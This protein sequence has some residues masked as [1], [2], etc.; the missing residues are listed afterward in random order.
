MK[1]KSR[2]H[3]QGF[4]L[5][6]MQQNVTPSSEVSDMTLTNP[7]ATVTLSDTC[8]P[9][10]TLQSAPIDTPLVE[11]DPGT[12]AKQEVEPSGTM[13]E[14]TNAAPDQEHLRQL[15]GRALHETSCASDTQAL[16]TASSESVSASAE[17]DPNEIFAKLVQKGAFKISELRKD[18]IMTVYHPKSS[19]GARIEHFED[20]RARSEA[21]DAVPQDDNPDARPWHPF[22]TCLDFEFAA[23]TVEAH[24]NHS[25]IDILL[26]IIKKV[27]PNCALFTLRSV[28]D[29]EKAWNNASKLRTNFEKH[30]ISAK[31]KHQ[32]F[33]YELYA[34]PL[35]KW[36]EDELHNPALLPYIYWDSCKMYKYNDKT[37]LSS[38]GTAKGYP[39]MAGITNIAACQRNG[40]GIGSGRIVGW[41]PIVPE[42]ADKKGKT[43]FTN[44]KRRLLYPFIHILSA[45]YEEQSVMALT[46][47]NNGLKPCPV[48]NISPELQFKVR[49]IQIRRRADNV[50]TVVLDDT[51]SR[52][53]KNELL[54]PLGLRAEQNAF[55]LV[56]NSD[57]HEAL[58][59]DRL[60]ANA[61]GL[62][63]NH[64][65]PTFQDCVEKALG[66]SAMGQIDQQMASLPCWC[67]LNHFAT[68]MKVHFT[69]G[70]KYE[71]IMKV[72]STSIM[73]I[74]FAVHNVVTESADPQ[75]YL[76]LRCMRAYLEH[77]M[78]LALELHTEQ[79]I[80]SGQAWL[81]H[82]SDLIDV[83]ANITF[84]NVCANL[85]QKYS[86]KYPGK[87]WNFP[88]FD[89]NM[90]AY[91]DI[92]DKG[93]TGQYTTK[94]YEK[95][96]GPS[97]QSYCYQTNKR[98][99]VPQILKVEHQSLV[100][101]NIRH[102]IEVWDELHQEPEEDDKPTDPRF[103]FGKL[104]LGAPQQP[105][106]FEAVENAQFI[107]RYL[108]PPG[109]PSVHFRASDSITECRFLKVDY[110]SAVTWCTLTDYLR[111]NPNFYG[112]P[113]YDGVILDIGNDTVI[114]GKL[115]HAFIC[116]IGQ[117]LEPIALV[118]PLDAPVGV[119]L[120]K[121]KHLG[122]YCVHAKPRIQ[123]EFFSLRPLVRGAVLVEDPDR[124]GDFFVMDVVDTDMFLRV[125]AIFH[126]LSSVN[127]SSRLL[128]GSAPNY[129][130]STSSP[131]L[132]WSS[133]RT[134]GQAG[135]IAGAG[136]DP[137]QR[138]SKVCERKSPAMPHLQSSAT[139]SVIAAP[140]RPQT[141]F[142][143]PRARP[144]NSLGPGEVNP[145]PCAIH[146]PRS[147]G[148]GTSTVTAA[149]SQQPSS[150]PGTPCSHA[151]STIG[152]PSADAQRHV[153]TE[154]VA[155]R[156]W[157]CGMAPAASAR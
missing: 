86:K 110:E 24:L 120:R 45:D 65:W 104:H 71:D 18:D 88:K 157:L 33:T 6:Y 138:Q 151:C 127:I 42:D 103:N 34:R 37:R 32:E 68:V 132:F 35:W 155:Y 147:S 13:L 126:N 75:G 136:T 74:I 144:N 29:L 153:E 97:K 61:G 64:L 30:E 7:N 137:T 8:L 130:M 84:L 148:A 38:F 129:T 36:V 41:L 133:H 46:R 117:D 139:L 50:K 115:L 109:S 128:K 100:A 80:A 98:D 60:H 15:L 145:L 102:N 22:V 119:H 20:F 39:V 66:R 90:H 56:A 89:A 21:Q 28:S 43:T 150:N 27:A 4:T 99:F 54:K 143:Y 48:C 95:R 73:S 154:L 135:L 17:A 152:N 79:T 112:H 69:D 122:L 58:S 31:Y 106:C 70:T 67:G 11:H 10:G 3:D 111:C 63:S 87:N 105:S 140:V 124:Y 146:G 141:A 93:C 114:F 96:H 49:A 53:H 26:S 23:L 1:A 82:F 85:V 81:T 125:K 2:A 40:S 5:E 9:A 134:Y 19:L 121:D 123:A 16:Q 14:F 78:H 131:Y 108:L 59:V 101:M 83:S 94:T 76:L 92:E 52:T 77:D 149:I 44:F 25:Q 142:R 118:W 156:L 91:D 116:Q 12:A 51:L 62:S 107:N 72:Q 57:P 47:G 55:W 113:R